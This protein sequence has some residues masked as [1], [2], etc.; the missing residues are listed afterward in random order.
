M[1]YKSRGETT[2]FRPW[3]GLPD[4]P[5]S[6]SAVLDQSQSVQTI[7]ASRS[8]ITVR[9]TA[10][11]NKTCFHHCEVSVIKTTLS[12]PEQQSLRQSKHL[13]IH[14]PACLH[15]YGLVYSLEAQWTQ[16]QRQYRPPS[17]NIEHQCCGYSPQRPEFL[18]HTYTTQDIT[19]V[20][21]HTNVIRPEFFCQQTWQD[22]NRISC[23]SAFIGPTQR[24]QV[25]ED[26][27][28]KKRV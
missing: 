11:G 1:K 10:P 3:S 6:L 12:G 2:N 8:R 14:K 22:R 23:L 26:E 4:K 15:W 18:I 19:D 5:E 25:T 17:Y 21:L 9:F 13:Y 16:V 28:N 7:N 24:P 27:F 20:N